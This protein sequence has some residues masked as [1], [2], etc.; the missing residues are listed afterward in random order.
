MGPVGS[1]LFGANT[2]LA[3]A[4][5]TMAGTTLVGVASGQNLKDSL[6]EGIFA[7]MSAG[8]G[9]AIGSRLS[10]K[11]GTAVVRRGI[12]TGLAATGVGLLRGQDLNKALRG[13]LGALGQSYGLQV[14]GNVASGRGA[15]EGFTRPAGP[16]IFKVGTE[17]PKFKITKYDQRGNPI[18]FDVSGDPSKVTGEYGV[19]SI[20]SFEDPNINDI[21][22]ALRTD[23]AQSQRLQGD[24]VIENDGAGFAPGPNYDKARDTFDRYTKM[25]S[26]K[27][28]KDS[29]FEDVDYANRSV[30]SQFKSQPRGPYDLKPTSLAEAPGTVTVSDGGKTT[31]FGP[32][33]NRFLETTEKVIGAPFALAQKGINTLRNF[34]YGKLNPFEETGFLPST[35][36]E[37]LFNKNV[38]DYQAF[39][40]NN[41][42][43]NLSFDEYLT[44]S[45]KKPNMFDIYGPVGTAGL[46][47]Y[48]ASGGFSP[49]QEEQ[50]FDP[51]YS[52]LDYIRDNPDRFIGSYATYIPSYAKG[53]NV[54][55]FPRKNGAIRGPGTGT[56]DDI[57]AMLSDGEFVFTAKAVRGL[58]KGSRRKGAAK[59]YKLMRELEKRA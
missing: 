8:F 20:S 37:N 46:G 24:R 57:P 34:D 47:A 54:N 33:K 23:S 30:G 15:F 42:R 45:G 35:R 29:S 14:L 38:A 9:Q 31:Y 58:G 50:V 32:S 22:K 49:E 51:Y 16:Q 17:D 52:G 10:P 12:G 55:N 7:G 25:L 59:M 28:N 41:P 5:N 2:A 36:R 1:S 18:G 43:M 11:F 4:F 27:I 48:Y 13:G 44:A 26:D 53:G 40:D 19:D 21:S 6:K 56:S 3:T 39:R